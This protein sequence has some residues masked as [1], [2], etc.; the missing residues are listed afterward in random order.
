MLGDCLGRSNNH[1]IT[2]F[3]SPFVCRELKTLRIMFL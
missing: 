1:P 3:N 2:E